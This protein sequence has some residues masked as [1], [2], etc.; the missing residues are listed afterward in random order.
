MIDVA[1]VREQFPALARQF[2]GKPV[3]YFDNPAGT[4]VPRQTIEGF[5]RYLESSNANV[6][7]SFPNS[8]ETD[9]LI[10]EARL[11]MSDFLGASSSREIVFGQNMTTLAF[12][13]SRALSRVLQPGDEIVT[14][15]LEH[16][17]NVA[18]WL[19]LRERGVVI[20]FVDICQDG[21]LDLQS[22]DSA[23][24]ARTSLLAVGLASNALGTIN[25]VR[26][27]ADMARARGAL[28]FV[29]AVHF[30]PHG[31]IDV[32]AL[33]CDLLIC[34]SY[35]FFGPHLGVLYGRYEVLKSL[36]VDRV[37]PAGE[38]PP[39]RWETGTKS[40]EAL[41]GL[42]GTVAYLRSL[43]PGTEANHREQLR[44]AMGQIRGY[45]RTLTERLI[46]G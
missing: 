21:T 16:D 29:D 22:A 15:R 30:A 24:S 8:Q 20:R 6:G 17:A 26:R 39:D 7:G 2:D 18:P 4:Q 35:K 33:A 14:T 25:D 41:A 12:H 37:R 28:V 9:A 46:N 45:E 31:S 10:E 13:L 11:A 42:L 1:A 23:F 34:S 19:A 5:T 32:Q 3:V 44:R 27:L 36:P 43:A 38:D 40:H